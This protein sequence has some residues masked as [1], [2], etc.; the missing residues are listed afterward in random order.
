MRRIASNKTGWGEGRDLKFPKDESI[1]KKKYKS[2]FLYEYIP[3]N[4]KK[5][6]FV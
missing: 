4:N 2:L 3:K 5:Y 1:S 6:L